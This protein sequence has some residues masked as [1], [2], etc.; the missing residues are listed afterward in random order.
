MNPTFTE[1]S[2]GLDRLATAD[3][4]RSALSFSSPSAIEIVGPYDNFSEMDSDSIG[5]ACNLRE[6]IDW[7]E[8]VRKMRDSVA[9]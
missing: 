4:V 7:L 5:H 8:I 6:V 2:L 3:E 9:N 1:S